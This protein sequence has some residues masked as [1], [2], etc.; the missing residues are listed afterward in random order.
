MN[1]IAKLL[2]KTDHFEEWQTR[3]RYSLQYR[4]FSGH[5]LVLR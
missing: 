1:T 2:D 4:V 5:I 3:I